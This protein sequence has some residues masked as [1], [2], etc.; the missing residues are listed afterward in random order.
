M[1]DNQEIIQR[2]LAQV[3]NLVASLAETQ[4]QNQQ[5]IKERAS[6]EQQLAKARSWHQTEIQMLKDKYHEEMIRQDERA[7][8]K[9][10]IEKEKAYKREIGLRQE[11]LDH[12]EPGWEIG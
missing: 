11:L 9:M 7:K 10:D 1:E 8:T 4:K 6:L 5:L 2:L 3:E 12:K